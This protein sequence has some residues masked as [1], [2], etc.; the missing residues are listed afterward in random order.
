VSGG[1]VFP[2]SFKIESAKASYH[3]VQFWRHFAMTKNVVYIL[4][5]GFSAPLGI[6]TMRNFIDEARKLRRGN[7]K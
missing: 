4:G 7:P 1:F 5:A 2:L 6:P 3:I